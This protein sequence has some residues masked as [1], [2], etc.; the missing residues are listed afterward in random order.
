[1]MKRA[2]FILSCCLSLVFVYAGFIKI[3]GSFAFYQDVRAYHLIPD[4]WAW[5]W[6]HSLPWLEIVTGVALLAKPTR[7]A[8]SLIISL[9][10]L[11]F[12]SALLS[13]WIR[14]LNID[15]G[16]FGEGGAHS[17]YAWYLSRD[18]LMLL[19]SLYLF[20]S[21]FTRYAEVRLTPNS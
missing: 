16:C 18:S 10:L 5:V 2:Y 8:S 3:I 15:C 13:S 4:Q 21:A 7:L 17:N 1:M 20:R 6:A 19:V 11:L 9:L 14:G 12:M